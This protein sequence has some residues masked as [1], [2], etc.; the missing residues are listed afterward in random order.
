ME[1]SL[2][3]IN[4]IKFSTSNSILSSSFDEDHPD[5]YAFQIEKIEKT[6]KELQQKLFY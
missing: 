5:E 2:P 3:A 6:Q 1:V 4:I